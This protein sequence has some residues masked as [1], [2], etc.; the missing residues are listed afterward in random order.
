MADQ[1][2]ASNQTCHICEEREATLFCAQCF[3][4]H[5]AKYPRL[6]HQ[7]TPI[8]AL[9]QNPKEYKRRNEALTKAAAELRRNLDKMEQCSVEFAEM[10]QNCINYLTKYRTWWLQQ[11]HT[12]KEEL[13]LMVETAIQEATNYLDQGVEPGSAL[14]R[15][16]WTVPTEE[17]QVFEYT[18]NT[19]DLPTLCPYWAHYQNR[20]KS[21]YESFHSITEER[22]EE[23]PLSQVPRDFFAAINGSGMEL[24]DFHTHTTTQ[25]ILP[26]DVY[27]G[28]I[29]VDRTTVLIVG[30]EVLTMDLLS[31]QSTLLPPLLTPRNGVGVAQ[32]GNTVFAFGGDDGNPMRVCEKSSVPPTHWTPLP[33]MHYARSW[34]TP[35]AFKALLYLAATYVEDHRAVESFSPHTETFTVLPVSLPPELELGWNSV[36]F[37]ANG[38]LLLLTFN[39]Q[40]A[41]WKVG[42]PHFH[43]SAMDRK[44]YSFCPPLI[45]GTD[46]FI[47]NR[48][49][50][51][52]EKWSVQADRFV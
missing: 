39:K 41:R 32:V 24:Y 44:Y 16:M 14:G 46:V 12:D 30:E 29:Q 4:I 19:P 18:V 37:V 2:L 1:I 33:P 27:S 21:I 52:V 9:N 26:I 5:Q 43:V 40:M 35:C 31:L 38:E 50:P 25:H 28:Y 15:A 8:A 48:E 47:G 6:I 36:A 34:F 49:G 42:E 22:K 17:L 51:K 7:V 45:V 10:M 23:M 3:P 20:L 13:T 11:L